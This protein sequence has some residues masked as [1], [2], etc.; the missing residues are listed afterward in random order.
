[1]IP[2]LNTIFLRM[3]ADDLPSLQI[4]DLEGAPSDDLFMANDYDNSEDFFFD[5]NLE[6][7][8]NREVSADKTDDQRTQGES[9]GSS[10]KIS[11]SED[12]NPESDEEPHSGHQED[13]DG[14]IYDYGYSA[15][16]Q[17]QAADPNFARQWAEW[18]AAQNAPQPQPAD[19][20][21][22]S[23][24]DPTIIA[25]GDTAAQENTSPPTQGHGVQETPQPHEAQ[26]PKPAEALRTA[27]ALD[28]VLSGESLLREGYQGDAVAE[29]QRLLDLDTTDGIFSADLAAQ[30]AKFQEE[31]GIEPSGKVDQL[32]LQA[33][34]EAEHDRLHPKKMLASH[35]AISVR[36]EQNTHSAPTPVASE[37]SSEAPTEPPEEEQPTD[38][39]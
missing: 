11:D 3:H 34:K 12:P 1:L 37:S 25:Q 33:L 38:E 10:K 19:H 4:Y 30:I 6:H 13:F 31:E 36:A 39:N 15:Y 20:F 21:P 7:Q 27:P 5:E 8:R 23:P 18:E 24:E 16:L 22:D 14:G 29:V 26:L 32:T 9:T 28:A 35:G 2:S 17:K